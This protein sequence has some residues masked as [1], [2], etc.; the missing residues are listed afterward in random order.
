MPDFLV[1]KAPDVYELSEKNKLVFS[2]YKQKKAG[3]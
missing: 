1:Q 3:C 2:R